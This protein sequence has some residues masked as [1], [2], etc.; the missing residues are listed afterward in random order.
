MNIRAALIAYRDHPPQ[1]TSFV[2]QVFDFSNLDLFQTNLNNMAANGGGDHPEAVWPGVMELSKLAWRDGSDRMAYLIGDAPPHG[3]LGVYGD[4]WPQG[5]PSGITTEQLVSM[6]QELKIQLNAHSIANEKITT[7][8][9]TLLTEPTKGVISVGDRA[10]HTTELYEGTLR[11]RSDSI[12]SSRA[13]FSATM[14]SFGTYT[15]ANA[16]AT[17]TTLG[18]S[19]SKAAETIAYLAERGITE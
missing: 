8:A 13:L 17:A 14:D 12:G 18:M 1:D 9:F 10:Q 3:F 19:G 4:A 15:T 6:L 5:D 7:D 2:T 16:S 11:G